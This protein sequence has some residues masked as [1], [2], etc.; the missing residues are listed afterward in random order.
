MNIVSWNLNG[1]RACSRHGLSQWIQD[2]NFDV[3]CFQEVRALEEQIPDDVRQLSDFH[4]H[5]FPAEKKGYSGVGILTRK[6]PIQVFRGLG[7][8]EFD[9]EGR[10]I[11]VELDDL[12]IFSIYFPNS[13]SAGK[14][15]DYKINFCKELHK[16]LNKLSKK[17]GKAIV[18]NGDFNIAHEEIDLARPDDNHKSAGFLPEER[19]WM[20]S[21]LEAGWIDTFRFLNPELK[22]RYSWWSARTRARDRNIGWRIDYHCIEKKWIDHIVHAE[23]HDD[24]LGSDHCPVSLELDFSI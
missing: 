2:N 10:V 20:G 24:V 15:I 6:K 9:A 16:F 8:K 19:A 17:Y 11:G 13:Q 1:I 7:K 5:W 23:I 14:R 21:F 22:D 3:F 12:F 4:M 18:V